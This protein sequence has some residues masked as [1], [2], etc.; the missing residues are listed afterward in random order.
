MTTTTKNVVAS[1]SGF[2]PC[3]D[4]LI[5]KYGHTA[6]L[7]WGKIWRYEQMSDGVCRAAVLRLASDLGLTD[8]TIAKH[9]AALEADGYV[10]DKTPNVRNVPHIYKTTPKLNLKISVFMDDQT[11]GTEKFRSRYGKIPYEE[12]T[13]NR[14][15]DFTQNIFTAYESNIGVLTPMIAEK[16]KDAEQT[17]PLTWIL[18]AFG[19]A[20]ENNKRNWRYIETILKRWKADGKDEGKGGKPAPEPTK[21]RFPKKID[22][23][24]QYDAKGDVI[25]DD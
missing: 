10:K 11:T 17:Y 20:V 19:L 12:S 8:K 15:E 24:V 13:T 22:G 1:V 7:I 25:Y 4:M 23:R 3:P 5:E 9:I 16:L 2:T 18:E 6:A 21:K 14:G